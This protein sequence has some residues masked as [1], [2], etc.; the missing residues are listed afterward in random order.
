MQILFKV[1]G[2]PEPWTEAV[3]R[4]TEERVENGKFSIVEGQD[5]YWVSSFGSFGRQ[6]ESFDRN[7]QGGKKDWRD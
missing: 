5:Y 1:H 3:D 6:L 4:F 2:V 7:D